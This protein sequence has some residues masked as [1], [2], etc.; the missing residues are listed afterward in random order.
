[1]QC[2]INQKQL[3]ARGGC[4]EFRNRCVG[5]LPIDQ[6]GK[7]NSSSS[8]EGV[9]SEDNSDKEG[10]TTPPGRTINN[11]FLL[12]QKNFNTIERKKNPSISNPNLELQKK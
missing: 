6:I 11:D 4:Y 9:V 8:E 5:N 1:M 2:P 12:F 10:G 7:R 3:F